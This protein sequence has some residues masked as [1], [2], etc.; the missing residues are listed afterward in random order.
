M[1]KNPAFDPGRTI[2][3]LEL[4]IE[5]LEEKLRQ[6]GKEADEIIEAC[7]SVRLPNLS[8][9]GTHALDVGQQAAIRALKGKFTLARKEA[10]ELRERLANDA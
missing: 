8:F 3:N 9:G 2:R 5:V 10:D 7:A 4:E 1:K 6:V